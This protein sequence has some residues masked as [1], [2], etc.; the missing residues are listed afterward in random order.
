MVDIIGTS[1]NDILVFQGTLQQYTVTLTN[2]YSGQT[3]EIDEEK[4]VNFARYYGQGG[5]D[6]IILTTYGDVIFLENPHTGEQMIFDVEAIQGQAGGDVIN[7][8]SNTI[9]YAIGVVINGGSE[10]DI[11][12]GNIGNDNINGG[13]GNDNID[14]G[15]GNDRLDGFRGDDLIYGGDGNDT[16]YGDTTTVTDT[17]VGNDTVYGGAGNDTISGGYGDDLLNGD[18]GNDMINGDFGS[19]IIHGGAGNDTLNGGEG[20]DDDFI[21]GEDGGD[22]MDGGLGADLLD[23]GRGDD[24]FRF[25]ADS[26]WA[27]NFY[28]HNVGSIYLPGTG[29]KVFL[30]GY[31]RGHDSFFGGEGWDKVVLTS[32]NDAIF[33]DDKYSPIN[34]AAGGIRLDSIEEYDAGDGDDI[35]DLTSNRFDALDVL[36]HGGSGND[37]LWSSAGNDTIHGDDG[38]DNIFGGGGD[39]ILYGDAGNDT[40][41]G[42]EDDDVLLG[43]SGNDSL[44][45][46]GGDDVL[47]GGSGD[48]LLEGGAGRDVFVFQSFDGSLDT[49][50][51]FEAGVGKDILNLTD[52]LAGFDPLTDLLSDFVQLTTTG[53]DVTLLIDSDGGADSF[54]SIALLKGGVGGA[55]VQDLVDDGNIVID[56]SIII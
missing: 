46:K 39:D 48:D 23:G 21:Y 1:G 49:I 32:G 52:L 38:D 17:V 15:P 45:G 8:A 19:D 35:V 30:A 24:T 33:L 4:N 18:D 37:H 3:I 2:P 7:L 25:V 22:V 13:D 44:Y 54:V 9:N 10:D 12:W 28:A 55:S 16:I 41:C 51:D 36:I 20:S 43:G 31:N 27:G 47:I 14:G 50:T 11:L 26:L 29:Q 53:S 56:Q 5:I 42:A 40:V 34:A 6:R